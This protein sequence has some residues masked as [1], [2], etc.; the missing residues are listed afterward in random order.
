LT[1]ALR[2][3][4]YELWDSPRFGTQVCV[5]PA[6]VSLHNP[7]VPQQ[8]G[9]SIDALGLRVNQTF[10]LVGIEFGTGRRQVRK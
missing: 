9:T 2:D 6:E 5:A 4:L 8:S 3:G 1:G 7:G 10:G